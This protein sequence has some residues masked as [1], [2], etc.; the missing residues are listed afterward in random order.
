M[1]A[2]WQTIHNTYPCIIY[3]DWSCTSKQASK[4]CK[5]IEET[6][7]DCLLV[8]AFTWPLLTLTFTFS[9]FFSLSFSPLRLLLFHP[10][11][12]G[13]YPG[14]FDFNNLTIFQMVRLP[15]C[16]NSISNYLYIISH[17]KVACHWLWH[18]KSVQYQPITVEENMPPV[19]LY[20]CCLRSCIG[21]S[22]EDSTYALK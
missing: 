11:S 13:G 5:L 21:T 6:K 15:P 2:V 12:T 3:V 4:Q 19:V 7:A 14:S 9:S 20:I 8:Q 16:D 18:T 10:L 17:K 1:S 22:T